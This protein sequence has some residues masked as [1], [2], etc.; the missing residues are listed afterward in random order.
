MV[1]GYSITLIITITI[2]RSS[3][4]FLITVKA[5]QFAGGCSLPLSQFSQLA[6]VTTLFPSL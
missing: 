1:Y 4:I 5:L 3:S 6:F 2:S